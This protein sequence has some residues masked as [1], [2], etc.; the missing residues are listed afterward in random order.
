M[1]QTTYKWSRQFVLMCDIAT[2]LHV[3][4]SYFKTYCKINVIDTLY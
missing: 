2:S 4:C 3:N 1:L